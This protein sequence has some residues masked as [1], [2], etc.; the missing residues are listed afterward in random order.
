MEYKIL[1]KS[2]AP[3]HEIDEYGNIFNYKTGHKMSTG[4]KRYAIVFLNGSR[5]DSRK[6]K[7]HYVHRLVA[8]YFIGEC[9]DGYVVNHKDGDTR[10]NHVS[11]LEYCS[12]SDNVKHAYKSGLKKRNPGS[13]HP[14]SKLSEWE[15]ILIRKLK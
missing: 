11:N 2:D 3:S 9:P 15:V 5:K 12:I 1:E 10:N 8:K 14:N 4:N 13:L 6:R 7:T